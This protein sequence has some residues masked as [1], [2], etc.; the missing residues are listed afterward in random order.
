MS[1]REQLASSNPN[2]HGRLTLD[3][4]TDTAYETEA[5][6]TAVYV[7][8]GPGGMDDEFEDEAEARAHY[9]ATFARLSVEPN[10]EAQAAYD[11]AHGTINGYAPWQYGREH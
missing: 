1:K 7:V 3:R 4:Y 6:H 11:D 5:E 2:R 8:R 9:E 10:W